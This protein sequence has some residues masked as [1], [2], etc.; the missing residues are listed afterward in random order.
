MSLLS[1]VLSF[2]R[3]MSEEKLSVSVEQRII[4]KFLTAEGVQPLEIL[5]MLEK[6]FGDA[7]LSRNR[8]FE[9]CKIFRDGRER[10]REREREKERE[11]KRERERER[12]RE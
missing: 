2:T 10:E 11:R 8:V 12:E 5:Q 3:E 9:W 1:L 4:I 7:C 6:Q